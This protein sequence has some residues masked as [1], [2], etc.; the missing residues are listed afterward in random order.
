MK[1]L[2]YRYGS[3][4]EP[5][6][7]ECFKAAGIEVVEEKLELEK[8]KCTPG[9]VV[10]RISKRFSSDT[11]LFVFSLNFFPAVSEICQVY[12]VPYVCWTVDSPVMELFSPSLK[13]SVNRVFFFDRAQYEY[14]G[15]E[16]TNCFYLPLATNISRWQQ[17]I[18]GDSA[19]TKA[20]F[21][22]DISMVGS[23]YSEKNPYRKITG[24]SDW[25]KGYADDAVRLS[26]DG[27]EQTFKYIED[28]IDASNELNVPT[29]LTLIDDIDDPEYLTVTNSMTIDL[30][31][32]YISSMEPKIL[33]F[34][35]E[36]QEFVIKDSSEDGSG[37]IEVFDYDGYE[38]VA[39]TVSK[40][41]LTLESGTIW[42][43]TEYENAQ[44][45]SINND[46]T[47]NVKGGKV[48]AY[49]KSSR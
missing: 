38:P 10:E 27:G 20:K 6:L 18:A 42:S 33:I 16:L 23:L 26:W 44:G 5:D 12:K 21:A 32:H 22:S 3:I 30:N 28:A 36:G 24:L 40:G 9:E 17:V 48:L 49:S 19:T 8:K 43:E 11:Y 39:V 25:A 4:C 14:F 2:F 37:I 7:I 47:L 15:K 13:N 29:T 45:I 34:N 31:G 35:G 1:I 41:T 46:G